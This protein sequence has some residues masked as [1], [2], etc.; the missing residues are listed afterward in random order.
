M[1]KID[2]GAVMTVVYKEA[3]PGKSSHSLEHETILAV[4]SSSGR[5]L[6]HHK[7]RPGSKSKLDIPL[8]MFQ[9]L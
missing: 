5:V 3:G 8:V 2:K 1:Q 9:Y 4:D 6:A 7:L